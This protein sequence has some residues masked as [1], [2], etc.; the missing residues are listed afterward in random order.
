MNLRT[1][2]FHQQAKRIGIPPEALQTQTALF[3]TSHPIDDPDP[4]HNGSTINY[5]IGQ[6][7]LSTLDDYDKTE[8]YHADLSMLIQN[9]STATLK[10]L[11]F[12]PKD[13]LDHL[14][15]RPGI[16]PL[17]DE[18]AHLETFPDDDTMIN[19]E[20]NFEFDEEY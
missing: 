6:L 15:Y 13:H 12:N 16:D 18:D 11:A 5:L 9:L 17:H 19:D 3:L 4:G 20:S 2:F 7:L 8:Q 10:H 14:F 1:T